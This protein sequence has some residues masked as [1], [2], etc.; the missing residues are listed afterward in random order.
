MGCPGRIRGPCVSVALIPFVSPGFLG[1]TPRSRSTKF[2][3]DVLPPLQ[4]FLFSLRKECASKTPSVVWFP[5]FP[6][7]PPPW[8][9]CLLK[10]GLLSFVPLSSLPPEA[11]FF[12]IFSPVFPTRKR[13]GAGWDVQDCDFPT[14][15][16]PPLI[17]S[18]S[19]A[20][21]RAYACL[22]GSATRLL[23][24]WFPTLL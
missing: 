23:P 17:F 12:P 3:N 1:S 10:D 7:F 4:L 19:G 2:T 6:L 5:H 9:D 13:L 11:S 16:S 24:F 20:A 14:Y 22:E 15:C 8:R 21:R 18:S